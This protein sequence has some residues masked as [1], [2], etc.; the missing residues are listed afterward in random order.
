MNRVVIGV[1]LVAAVLVATLVKGF[2]YDFI[3]DWLTARAAMQ[4]IDPYQ[5]VHLLIEQLGYISG[6]ELVIHPRL[7]G[8]LLLLLPV[9]WLP[10]EWTYLTGRL[11]VVG[12]GF[13][14]AWTLAQL[15]QW[16]VH[17]AFAA[18]P[19]LLLVW[20]FSEVLRFSQTTFL[21][22]GL[23]GVAILL[24][25]R[26]FAGFPLAAAVVLKG[27]PWLVIPALWI[28]GNRKTAYGA[29]IGFAG[30]NLAGL[31]IPSV[32]LSG[33]VRML[34]SS[35][36]LKSES[37]VSALGIPVGV[38]AGIGLAV[39]VVAARYGRAVVWALPAALATAPVLWAS[40][41]PVLLLSLAL[42]FGVSSVVHGKA[43]ALDVGAL[44]V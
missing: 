14:F 44:D 34:E 21:V 20:P 2:D 29:V 40:Y 35:L 25:N 22:G 7:P 31:A 9:G 1:S 24:G 32:T 36:T 23:I 3:Y 30:L 19:G 12:S 4:G 42:G 27:W 33:V 41:L 17:Y 37:L 8:A 11:L 26:W 10:V 28:S 6:T 18:V 43:E 16:P 38:A 13:F 15:R 5:P 39:V